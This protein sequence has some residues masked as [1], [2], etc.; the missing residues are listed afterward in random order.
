MYGIMMSREDT[1]AVVGSLILLL[2]H[3]L[4]LFEGEFVKIFLCRDLLFSDKN[5]S[6]FMFFDSV[7]ETVQSSHS[8]S[9]IIYML[10]VEG[11][12]FW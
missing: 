2:H 5:T 7:L 12:S 9:N 4:L 3:S 6:H 1:E 8:N 10:A 11:Q